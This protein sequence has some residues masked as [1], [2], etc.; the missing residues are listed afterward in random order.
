MISCLLFGSL[1]LVA[2]LLGFEDFG[3]DSTLQSTTSCASDF[4]IA[5]FQLFLI[6]DALRIHRIAVRDEKGYIAIDALADGGRAA[7]NYRAWD[8]F[9]SDDGRY[10]NDD[11]VA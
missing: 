8:T 11:A 10:F 9:N 2:V 1:R 4:A 5:A 6:I 7:V 3:K